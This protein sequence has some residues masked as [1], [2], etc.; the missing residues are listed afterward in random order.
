MTRAHPA[1]TLLALTVLAL[2]SPPLGARD[3][4]ADPERSTLE[5]TGSAQG[6]AFTGRFARFQPRIR[7]DPDRL[8]QARFDVEIDLASADTG[9]SERDQTLKG[10]D[11]FAIGRHPSARYLAERFRALPDGR[12][13]ADGQLTLR[14]LTRPVTL[15]FQ[16]QPGPGGD[17]T[18]LVLE[19]EA[20]LTGDT[21]LDRMQFDL[22]TGDWAD[23]DTLAHTV[24]VETRLVLIAEPTPSEP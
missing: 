13:A 7:F 22:G 12:Y 6:E 11:F 3:W 4:R 24:R 8:D 2:A 9:N 5:F 21:A 19:G 1:L 17:G 15:N 14:G 20:V 10:G 23:P 18:T 16:W